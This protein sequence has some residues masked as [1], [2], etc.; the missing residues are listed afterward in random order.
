MPDPVPDPAPRVRAD[1]DIT[2]K[3]RIRN[4]A[5]ALFA[6][7]GEDGTS[8]RAVAAEA[9]VTVGLIVHHY[10][11]KDALREAVDDHLVALFRGAIDSVPLDDSRDVGAARDRA[12][13]DML[14]A[15]PAAVDYLRRALLAPVGQPCDL[16]ERLTAMSLGYV[17]E[18]RAAGLATTRS[19][20]ATQTVGVMVRQLGRLFLQPLV[21]RVGA[22]VEEPAADGGRG[23]RVRLV[24]RV[25]ER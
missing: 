3:A 6:S 16:L 19:S 22:L 11:T 17:E 18:Q 7:G 15:N 10:G 8:L 2:A 5:L 24:V 20:A 1:G 12:V 21:E 14:A 13:A 4:A 25:E 23:P 9:G